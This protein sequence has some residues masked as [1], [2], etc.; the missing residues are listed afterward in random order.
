MTSVECDQLRTM[1]GGFVTNLHM[2]LGTDQAN[3]VEIEHGEYM[4]VLKA[5]D[6]NVAREEIAWRIKAWEFERAETSLGRVADQA[7]AIAERLGKEA[8]DVVIESNGLRLLPEGWAEF[9]SAFTHVIRNALD[10]GI[11]GAEGREA[12]GKPA[13][14]RIGLTTWLA[15]DDFAIEITD[16][17]R[18][19]DWNALR[20]RAIEIGLPHRDNDELLEALFR[21]GVTTKKEVSEFSGRGIGMGAIR[22]VCERMGGTMQVTS[23]EGTGTCL[24]FTWSNMKRHTRPMVLGPM[25]VSEG[26]ASLRAGRRDAMNPAS[27]FGLGQVEA[28]RLLVTEACVDMLAASGLA[29]ERIDPSPD[30][31]FGERHIAGFIGFT[32]GV[33]GSLVIAASSAVFQQ[34]LSTWPRGRPATPSSVDLLD[35]AGEMANQTLGRI[36]RRFCERGIDFEASTPTAV[37]GRHIGARSPSREG[38]VDLVFAVGDEI[39]CVCFEIVPPSD[40]VIFRDAAP[41]IECSV[42]GELVMF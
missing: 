27:T 40:G 4:S 5:L 17:G 19:I 3:R 16:D 26:G 8:P 6:G 29:A 20:A 28:L 15:K 22:A 23:T 9:W 31:V 38:I 24:R 11:E 37:N 10:H 30:S 18:G 12:A 7:R 35:W 33:R 42:E 13:R 39:V 2:L 41:P 1:W 32:G 21:D 36:K 14:G 34:T 25:A